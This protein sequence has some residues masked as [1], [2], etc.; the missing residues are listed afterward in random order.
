MSIFKINKKRILRVVSFGLVFTVLLGT[1]GCGKKDEPVDVISFSKEDAKDVYPASLD[2]NLHVTDASNLK[3]IAKSGLVTLLI[4]ESTYSVTVLETLAQKYWYSLPFLPPEYAGEYDYSAAPVTLTVVNGSETIHLNSQDNAVAFGNVAYIVQEDEKKDE[5]DKKK[6]NGVTVNYIVTLDDKTAKTIN[7]N[8]GKTDIALFDKSTAKKIEDKLETTDIAFFLSMKYTLKDGSLSVS[9]ETQNL[10]KNKSVK[11]T[12][13][14]VLEYLGATTAAEPGDFMLVPDGSGALI[15]TAVEQADFEKMNFV[16]YGDNSSNSA[17]LGEKP[18]VIGAYGIKTGDS[19]L[20]VLIESGD[21]IAKI[22]ADRVTGTGGLN[23]VGAGFNTT[24]CKDIMNRKTI[25]RYISRES[26]TGEIRLSLRFLSGSNATYSGMAAV[27]REQL[28]RANKLSTKTVETGDYLP[29]NLTVV[30][31]VQKNIV[32]KIPLK[33]TMNLTTFEQAQD[34][35]SRLKA[36]DV[37]SVFLRYKGALSG[38]LD[39]NDIFKAKVLRSLGG[40]KGFAELNDY[41]ITQKM[42]LFLDINI[43]SSGK[44]RLFFDS[45]YA[46]TILGENCLAQTKNELSDYVGDGYFNQSLRQISAISDAVLKVLTS[47]RQTDIEGF[48]LNDAC[49]TLYSDFS[50]EP[51]SRSNAAAEIAKQITALST[52]RKMMA[53]T[54]NFYAIKNINVISNIPMSLTITDIENP[55]YQMV[56]F[57]QLILHGIADYSGAPINEAFKPD[58][59]S[60]ANSIGNSNGDGKTTAEGLFYDSVNNDNQKELKDAMLRYIEYGACPSYEWSYKEL[61]KTKSIETYYF[62]DWLNQAVDFY[63]KANA[64]LADLRGARMV[65][66]SQVSPGVF[67]TEYEGSSKIYVNYTTDDADVGGIIVKARDFIR[68]Y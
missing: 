60:D 18:A 54:G 31:A 1:V 39:Q 57:I 30:G 51:F 58:D 64:A 37:N 14:G 42:N 38:G 6:I 33:S 41:M 28:I 50:K 10:S 47:F 27:C 36:K 66:H 8:L 24:Q 20:A 13:V 34:M 29:F 11:I 48:C 63:L 56:P 59:G 68:I 62:D 5:K 46:K 52:G 40:K 43:L 26:Y 65:R 19:A 7:D 23:K 15:Y 44:R 12:D 55:P 4:D 22:S 35:L 61:S 45:S 17:T 25:S 21:A 3:E 32:R 49:E 67:C 2:K 9:C 16:V 53:D